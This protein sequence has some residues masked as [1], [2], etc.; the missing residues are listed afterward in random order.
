MGKVKI[1]SITPAPTLED[2][3]PKPEEETPK[4]EEE[5]PKPEEKHEEEKPLQIEDTPKQKKQDY[6]TCENC[7]KS[8]LMKTYKYSHLKICKPPEPEQL[9]TKSQVLDS[10]A[11]PLNEPPAPPPPPAPA[12][13]ATAAAPTKTKKATPKQLPREEVIQKPEF[14]GY[15]SFNHL[16]PSQNSTDF[17]RN[18]REHRQQVRIQRVRSLIAQ[19]I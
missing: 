17:Y 14:N 7:N 11:L 12:A 18:E 2:E 5:T 8:M 9:R 19:A 6:I 15:V 4:P 13:P 3:T 10:K 16:S 1:V